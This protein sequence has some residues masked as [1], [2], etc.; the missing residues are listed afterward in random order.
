MT[1]PISDEAVAN[2]KRL[3]TEHVW[4]AGS[5]CRCGQPYGDACQQERSYAINTLRVTRFEVPEEVDA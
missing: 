4:L 1:V 3:Y 5:S 2:A